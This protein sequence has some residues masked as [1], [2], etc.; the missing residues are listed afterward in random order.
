MKNKQTISKT[1][2]IG[3]LLWISSAYFY[4]QN[5]QVTYEVKFKPSKENDIFIKENM[6]LKIVK[7]QSLF[8]SQNKA[9]IDSLVEQNNFKT[10]QATS[11]PLLRIKVLKHL[12]RNSCIVGVT[13]NQFKYWYNE[14]NPQYQGL[15]KHENYKG[16]ST[17]EAYTDFG[18]RKWH[19]LYTTD[20]PINDGP[21]IFSGLPGLVL[22]A[23]SEDGDYIFEMIAIKKI[24]NAS[25]PETYKENIKKEKLSQNI[26]N[27]IEDPA[28][29]R[30]TFGNDF[31]DSFTYD[32]K[33]VKDQN[34]KATNDHIKE[35]I[36]KFNNYPD[37]NLPILTF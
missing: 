37:K 6:I 4:A 34:Y 13:F 2:S 26:N 30:I 21:Y 24:E 23:E 19:I 32:F 14:K 33:G 1:I 36:Q 22:K 10:A 5:Y 7:D 25:A 17:N 16:Y 27:F 15:K 12:S 28:S 20:I 11:S 8:Y 9:A 18:Q 31:G 35:L 29:H 3:F